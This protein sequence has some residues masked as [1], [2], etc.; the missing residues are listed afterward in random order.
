MHHHTPPSS[1]PPYLPPSTTII[2][3]T[4]TTIITSLFAYLQIDSPPP[5]PV[6]P[7]LQ[8]KLVSLISSHKYKTQQLINEYEEPRLLSLFSY[9]L[10]SGFSDKILRLLALD[11]I[12]LCHNED[13]IKMLAKREYIHS[14]SSITQDQN[15]PLSVCAHSSRPLS[16]YGYSGTS[17][18]EQRTQ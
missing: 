7:G 11:E 2:T 16:C 14:L 12:A 1:S 18:S 15:N 8:K 3:T 13:K 6:S 10:H 17:H 9:A 4:T 5:L